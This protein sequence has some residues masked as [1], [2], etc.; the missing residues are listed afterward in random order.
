MIYTLTLN[1]AIDYVIGVDRFEPRIINRTSYENIYAGGKGL[2]VSTVLNNLGVDNIA[3]GFIAGP[4]G[5]MLDAMTKSSGIKSNFAR[6]KNGNTR[7]NVKMKSGTEETEI[8]GL[9]P[10]LMNEDVDSL[11]NQISQ[12]TK[13]DML[14]I[15]GSAPKGISYID[16]CEL[17]SRKGAEIVLDIS[18]QALLDCLKYK[19]LLVKPNNIELAEMLGEP[20]ESVD[21]VI[22]KAKKLQE[23]G[24]QN[25]MVSMAGDGAVLIDANGKAHVCAAPKG[26]VINSVGAGDTTV[27]AFIARYLENDSYED[28]LKYAVSAGSATAFKSGLATK[29]DIEKIMGNLD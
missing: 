29:E 19:P 24:A 8:N 16:I 9:G 13:E 20:I 2:N 15:S 21:D 7:I 18:G 25:V 1:P 28:I 23:L 17:V 5:D 11:M 26:I 22:K 10:Q 27:A 14:I 3:L 6:C 4:T 12:L